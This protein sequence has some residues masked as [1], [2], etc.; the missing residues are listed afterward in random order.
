MS[1]EAKTDEPPKGLFNKVKQGQ[2]EEWNELYLGSPALKRTG[3]TTNW[4]TTLRCAVAAGWLK[5]GEYIPAVNGTAESW[6]VDGVDVAEMDGWRVRQLAE[7]VDDI[8]DEAIT[9]PKN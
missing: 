4:G 6:K 7:W 9:I 5:Q 3:N 8:Y 2:L 1:D